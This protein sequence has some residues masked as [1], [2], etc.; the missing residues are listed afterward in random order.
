MNFTLTGSDRG[1]GGEQVVARMWRV[2]TDI[3]ARRRFE[4]RQIVDFDVSPDGKRL[5]AARRLE[6]NDI[7]VL[8]GL[9]RQ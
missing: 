5:V 9:Q 8:K 2:F 7:V 3:V 6:T 4:N 1:A